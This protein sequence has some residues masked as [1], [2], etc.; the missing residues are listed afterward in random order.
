LPGVCPVDTDTTIAGVLARSGTL[1]PDPD[2]TIWQE[3][4]DFAK[5]YVPTQF[6]ALPVDSDVSVERWLLHCGNY[7]MARKKQ[8][9]DT[10]YSITDRRAMRN[11]NVKSFIK[12]ERYS[13]NKHARPINSRADEFKTMCGP[14]FKLIEEVFF[15]H[16]DFIKKIPVAERPEFL[17]NK[18]NSCGL[19]VQCMDFKKM[20]SHFTQ[21]TFQLEFQFY[22]YMTAS[23]PSGALF[24]EEIRRVLGG[25]NFCHFKNFIAVLVAARMSGEMNTSLGNGFV[26]WILSK[27]FAFKNGCLEH[28]KG[29]FEGDD[30]AVVSPYIPT[31]QDYRQAGFQIEMNTQPSVDTAS[32]CGL[33][34][35]PED[36]VN[37]TDPMQELITFGWT[38]RR[39]VGATPGTRKALLKSKSLSM[40]Y[41]YAG[42]PILAALGRYGLR[43][44]KHADTRKIE[45]NLSLWEKD[46][47]ADA[48][49]A[50]SKRFESIINTPVG[51]KTRLLMEKMYGVLVEDQIYAEKYLDSLTQLQPL[52]MPLLMKYMKTEWTHYYDNYVIEYDKF[53]RSYYDYP[54]KIWTK[55]PLLHKEWDDSLFMSSKSY[56]LLRIQAHIHQ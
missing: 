27:F 28:H 30:S 12:D 42:C 10:F 34:F 29:I 14:I 43:M 18:L 49:D 25:Y 48:K 50:L 33:I 55:S 17:F 56:R 32:F 53:D 13:E 3:V 23:L 39:Y 51:M 36:K 24:M 47:M 44:T 6:K 40:I 2:P 37:V 52:H 38:N 54:P 35:D 22:E 5:W 11:T 31:V 15:K 45:K 8:L 1:T 4:M 9:L 16:A 7:T 26:N 21:L 46:Q 20:E 41:Q 19:P